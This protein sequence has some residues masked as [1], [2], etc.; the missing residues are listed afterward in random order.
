[1]SHF[2]ATTAQFAPAIRNTFSV[3]GLKLE[4]NFSK[5]EKLMNRRDRS[6]S[7]TGAGRTTLLF[8]RNFETTEEKLADFETRF[9]AALR[10][11]R[12]ERRREKNRSR[13]PNSRAA[14]AK[15]DGSGGTMHVAH[16][17]TRRLFARSL[18]E[19]RCTGTTTT[20]G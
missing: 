12:T 18:H 5:S 17:R 6:R 1:M 19:G 8:D 9:S 11:G 14:T 13:S 16:L 10:D 20:T 15:S 2:R 7:K 4:R 3:G